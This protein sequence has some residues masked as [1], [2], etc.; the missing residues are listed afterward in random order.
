VAPANRLA[1]GALLATLAVG[2]FALLVPGLVRKRDFPAEVPTPPRLGSQRITVARGATA[3]WPDT[4]VERHARQARLW[5]ATP[6]ADVVLRLDGAGYHSAGRAVA[7]P[8]GELRAPVAAPPGDIFVR[9]CVANRGR[10][11]VALRS[12]ARGRPWFGLYEA[13]PTSLLSRLGPTMSRATAF[14]PA[15]VISPLLWLV[16]LLAFVGIPVAVV[17]AAAAAGRR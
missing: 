7:A 11:P 10:R 12:A 14:R 1:L 16:A 4:V 8:G 9:M 13:H 3:C 6:R 5:T 15:F 2:V 17:A